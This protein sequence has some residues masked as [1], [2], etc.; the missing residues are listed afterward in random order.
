M[1]MH[2]GFQQLWIRGTVNLCSTSSNDVD[3]HHLFVGSAIQILRSLEN[4]K[5]LKQRMSVWREH[6]TEKGER[7]V[8]H[9]QCPRD[10]LREGR[11]FSCS[12][13]GSPSCGFRFKRLAGLSSAAFCWSELDLLMRSRNLVSI[14]SI[15]LCMAF[16]LLVFSSR[17]VFR[18]RS[19]SSFF[20]SI[21][22]FLVSNSW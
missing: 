14:S 20:F 18:A 7:N 17:A 6:S 19:A 3:S 16:S 2:E 11:G 12:S 5:S 22:S 10:R 13:S 15:C 8:C 4:T 9:I 21:S 1:M